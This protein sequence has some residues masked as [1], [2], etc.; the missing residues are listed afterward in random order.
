MKDRTFIQKMGTTM[1]EMMLFKVYVYPDGDNQEHPV[2]WKSDDYVVRY[3]SVCYECHETLV[4][5]YDEPFA[6]C[7]CGTREWY[8]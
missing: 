1:K 2:D 6:H 3:T 5:D 7:S 8:K 4:V